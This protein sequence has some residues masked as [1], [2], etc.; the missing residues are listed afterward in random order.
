MRCL[1]PD[2]IYTPQGVLSHML[3]SI[4]N[5]GRII[6]VADFDTSSPVPSG[7]IEA[8]P[9]TLLLPSFVNA[10]SHVFQRALRGGTHR[11]LSAH[12]SFWTWR[13]AMYALANRLK[14]DN[15][16]EVALHTYREM[17][18]AGYASVGEFH[19]LHHQP[20]GRPYANPNTMAEAVLSAGRDAG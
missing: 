8:L 6:S 9:N 4:S 15:L 10:H 3:T 16:S 5:D 7:T 17:L 19:Y 20:D 12:D 11:S 18:V 13:Q 2:Y 1:A 14:P